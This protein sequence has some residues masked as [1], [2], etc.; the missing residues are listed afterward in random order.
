MIN[1]CGTVGGIIIG[2]GTKVLGRNPS[3][4]HF[5]GYISHMTWP[6][7]EPRMLQWESSG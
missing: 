7:I 6:G 4:C 1:E 3:Q 2:K 5:V